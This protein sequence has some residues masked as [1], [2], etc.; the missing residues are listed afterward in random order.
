MFFSYENK[1]REMYE[2]YG[3]ENYVYKVKEKYNKKVQLSKFMLFFPYAFAVVNALYIIMMFLISL[4]S[5]MFSIIDLMVVSL[6]IVQVYSLVQVSVENYKQG[7]LYFIYPLFIM[8]FMRYSIYAIPDF[9]GGNIAYIITCI[10]VLVA[11]EITSEMVVMNNYI[12]LAREKQFRKNK[13]DLDSL[14]PGI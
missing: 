1:Y 12:I 14:L 11:M 6:F 5:N 3:Y 7:F 9:F 13:E 4:F 8:F 10:M 2:K